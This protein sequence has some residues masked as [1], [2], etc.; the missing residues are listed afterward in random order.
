MAV[1]SGSNNDAGPHSL[2]GAEAEVVDVVPEAPN[3]LLIH[4]SPHR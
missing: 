1:D 3:R 4:N 2:I